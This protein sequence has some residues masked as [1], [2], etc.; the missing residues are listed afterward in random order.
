M[1]NNEKLNSLIEESKLYM[2]SNNNY[3][4]SHGTYSRASIPMQGWIAECEDFIMSE[5]GE[6][7]VPWKVYS[8]FNQEALDG[9]YQD[10]FD[11]EKNI[12]IS[13]LTAC[14]RISP[15]K[16]IETNYSTNA[17]STE[18]NMNQVFVVHGHNEE[19][20]VKVAR[21]IEKLG[22]EPII[23]HEQASSGNTIIE[24][25][26]EYSDVGFGVVLYTACDVGAK[27]SSTPDLK[28]RAR[29]NVIFEHGYLIGKLTR[30][31]VCA[32]VQG[33]IELP[34][35]ISGVVY[36]PIDTNEAWHLQLAKELKKAGYNVD[37][38]RL[39]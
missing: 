10:T 13:A 19:V 1:N 23:L 20:K 12:I 9:N 26:E 5:Y 30:N 25:I 2:F 17:K 36:T 11:K 27:N 22:F 14:L 34:N 29:Q 32:L 35:D 21:F 24:K 15:K 28:L 3:T 38:N 4:V 6:N 16:L 8:R 7:S 31:N 18:K 33:D 37:M 39:I